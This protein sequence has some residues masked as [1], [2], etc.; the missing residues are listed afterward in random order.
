MVRM[1]G[2]W[3]RASDVIAGRRGILASIALLFVW[4]PGLVRAAARLAVNGAGPAAAAPMPG[5]F[6]LVSILGLAVLVLGAIGNL[7]LVA[8]ASDP[9]VGRGEALRIAL[10][11]LGA[12]V[13][14]MLLVI[15]AFVVL[16]VPLVI[17]VLSAY[18][19]L[20]A[21]QAGAVPQVSAGLGLFVLVYSLV[22]AVFFL[23]VEARLLVVLVPVIVN[24]R[25][26]LRSVARAFALTRGLTWRIVGVL[27]LFLVVFVVALL[28]AQGV[29][30]VTLRLLLGYD[31]LALA[32][33]LTAA[34]VS[35]VSCAF[36]V[37]ISVFSA[38]L[39]VAA[40]DGGSLA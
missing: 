18:P 24:E 34:I 11:R 22:L 10:N 7:A 19:S 25:L 12:Y 39:Y 6:W 3:D 36:S 33:F 27:L 1:S 2:V 16:A 29:V 35:M 4:L 14:I 38:Q 15:T 23:W 9:S 8:V 26:G 13:G 21:L 30:G 28:A 17:A 37:V 31:H 32:L 5:S 40:R 20:A